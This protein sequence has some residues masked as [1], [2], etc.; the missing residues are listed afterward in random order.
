[1]A[2]SADAQI[3]HEPPFVDDSKENFEAVVANRGALGTARPTC[4]PDYFGAMESTNAKVG[5]GVLTAPGLERDRQI[6][7][8]ALFFLSPQR[9]EG[10]EGASAY[11]MSD[12]S[13]LGVPHTFNP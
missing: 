5:R 8:N 12:A 3:D 2:R 9:G 6:T 10:W 1:M 11:S 4:A 13:G 7:E